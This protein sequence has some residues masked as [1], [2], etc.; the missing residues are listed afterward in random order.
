MLAITAEHDIIFFVIK[1]GDPL[2]KYERKPVKRKRSILAII[3][4]I[5]LLLIAGAIAG[6]VIYYNSLLNNINRFEPEVTTMPSEQLEALL[7][8]DPGAEI[9][10]GA[11]TGTVPSEMDVMTDEEE[12][13]GGEIINILLIGQDTRYENQRGLSD[14]MI[15]ISVNTETKKLVMTSFMRDL[16]IEI[17]SSKGGYYKQRINTAYP[18]GGLER[19]NETLTHNFGVE[20]DHN[21]EVDFSGFITI[22]DA[23]G[24]VDIELSG[25]EALYINSGHHAGLKEGLNHLNGELTL[26]YARLREFDSDFHRTQRQRTVLLK[27]FDKVKNL[28]LAEATDLLEE[29]FPLITTDMT[30]LEITNYMIK[31][32]PLLPELEITTQRIPVD[33]SW[34]GSNAGSEEKPMYVIC[35]DLTKNRELLRQ[36]IGE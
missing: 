20:V 34:W 22:V 24:G 1:G 9:A 7:S 11:A 4:L 6:G 8:T 30:N 16:Y 31:L 33:G 13:I 35:C 5:L 36:T 12:M 2:G 15:L 32:L 27:L 26:S 21:I 28:S 18:V 19:L 23:L 14:T 17:P 3:L 25:I 10:E 29:F